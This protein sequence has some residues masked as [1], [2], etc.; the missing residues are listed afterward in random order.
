MEIII[1][2]L[3][4]M[5]HFAEMQLEP[6]AVNLMD[7]VLIL[8]FMYNNAVSCIYDKMGGWSIQD[9]PLGSMMHQ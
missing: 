1:C 8:D 9:A 4:D 7:H 5:Y 6:V 2:V 3:K